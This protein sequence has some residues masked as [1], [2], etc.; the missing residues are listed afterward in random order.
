M[1]LDLTGK[2]AV[3]CG[4][5]QGIGWASAVELALL[6]ASVTLVARNEEKLKSAVNQLPG[7]SRQQHSFLV[8]DFLEPDTVKHAINQHAAKNETHILI[9]NTGGPPAGLAIDAKPEDFIKAF[10]AHL[11][12]GQHLVQALVPGMKKN[13]Y[14]RIVN[15]ISTSVKIPIRGLGVSNTIRGAVANWSKTLAT[16]LAPFGITVNTVLPGTTMTGRLEFVI[17]SNAECAGKS[18]EEEKQKM[19]QEVPMGRISEAEEVAAAV[20]FL[21][22]PAAGYITGIN[23]P[24]D[25]GRTGSL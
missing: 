20:A 9:N 17:K 23:L 11:I 4:S 24:V 2:R 1:N 10:T 5:T 21:C 14:G 16:E 25:G 22:S 13:G 15:V 6:G 8:A 3:V 7:N 19:I 12:C 18:F